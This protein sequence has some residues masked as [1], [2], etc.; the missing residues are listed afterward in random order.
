MSLRNFDL[1]KL[2]GL[3]GIYFLGSA[4]MAYVSSMVISIVAKSES[5]FT[6]VVLYDTAF[7]IVVVGGLFL[8]AGVILLYLNS[9][10]AATAGITTPPKER[11]L[12]VGLLVLTLVTIVLYAVVPTIV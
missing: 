11:N 4:A 3:L 6:Q 5:V 7:Y 8:V 9:Q 10:E 12:I 2:N 1:S